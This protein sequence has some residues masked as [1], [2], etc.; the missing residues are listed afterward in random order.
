MSIQVFA[1]V[2]EPTYS[3]FSLC[4]AFRTRYNTNSGTNGW[5]SDSVSTRLM[6]PRH[7]Y[8]RFRDATELWRGI[9]Y[10]RAVSLFA[11][12]SFTPSCNVCVSVCCCLCLLE[13]SLSSESCSSML[14]GSNPRQQSIREPKSCFLVVKSELQ[15][16]QHAAQ[17]LFSFFFFLF[18]F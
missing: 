7:T 9:P 12:L 1:C 16:Q 15:Q 11:F 5:P 6:S 3:L 2:A 4:F 13:L 17:C 8:T 14:N 18:F 10:S